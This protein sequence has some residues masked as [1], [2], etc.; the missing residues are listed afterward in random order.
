MR[1]VDAPLNM[2]ESYDF[3]PH[4]KHKI[5]GVLNI[6]II[7]YEAYTAITNVL[8]GNKGVLNALFKDFVGFVSY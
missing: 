7:R 5:K 3:L 2:P 6:L 1:C 8:F 4:T